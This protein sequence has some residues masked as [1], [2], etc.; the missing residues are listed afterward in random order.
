MKKCSIVNDGPD[1][2][3]FIGKLDNGQYY[4]DDEF[5]ENDHCVKSAEIR[6]FFWSVYSCSWI[7]STHWMKRKKTICDGIP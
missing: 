7:L 5:F 4:V 2:E 6:S 1:A 3:K